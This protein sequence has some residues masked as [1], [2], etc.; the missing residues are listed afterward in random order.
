M[1]YERL[2]AHNYQRRPERSLRIALWRVQRP[3]YVWL[4]VGFL[5][6]WLVGYLMH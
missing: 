3:R 5:F 4:A 2:R 6:G 1:F